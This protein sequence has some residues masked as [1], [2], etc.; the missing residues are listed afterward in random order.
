MP[1]YYFDSHD[2]EDEFIDDEGSDLCDDQAARDEALWNMPDF[3]RELRPAGHRDY[4]SSVR[5]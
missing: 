1:R 5:D 4:V 3:T 2:G